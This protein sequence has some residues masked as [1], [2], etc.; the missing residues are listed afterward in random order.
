MK[1]MFFM[2][3]L[4]L[5]MSCKASDKKYI[6]NND[7]V[8]IEK[9]S[10]KRIEKLK[11][12][13]DMN[14]YITFFELFPNSYNELVCFYGFDDMKGKMPLYD[15][16]ESHINFL[17]IYESKV[18]PEQFTIKLYELSKN[19]IWD[20]DCVGLFQSKLS[21]FIMERPSLILDVVRTKPNNEAIGFWYFVFDGSNK[22]DLQNKKKFELIY[23]KIYTLDN[24]QGMLLKEQFEKMYR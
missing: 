12:S 5:I 10:N 9:L 11:L 13:F 16:Y 21:N 3:L 1:R 20:A 2:I 17:F 7:N 15:L 22:Y 8:Q 19:G 6:S 14:D 18:S 24:E 23:E 4:F